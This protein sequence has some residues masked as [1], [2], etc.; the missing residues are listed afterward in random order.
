MDLSP[1]SLEQLEDLL[2]QLPKLLKKREKL[3]MKLAL[4]TVKKA[5]RERGL[6]LADLANVSISEVP[7]K[8]RPPIAIKYRHPSDST[9]TW[10]GRGRQPRWVVAFIEAGGKIEQLAV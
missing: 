9:L 2:V 1:L 6:E 4:D 10:T 3:E 8:V 5:A 7:A